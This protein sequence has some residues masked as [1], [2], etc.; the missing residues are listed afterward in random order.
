MND[1]TATMHRW[2]ELLNH[3]DSDGIVDL[4][5]ESPYI[6]NA[7]SPELSG[8]VAA[9]TLVNG[10]F[11]RTTER[12]FLVHGTALGSTHSFAWWTATLTFKAGSTVAGR[13]LAEPF[14]AEIEGIDV[15]AF[16]QA[17]LIQTVH[18]IHETTTVALAAAQHAVA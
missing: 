6:K 7:A 9:R 12:S 15:F 5:A 2:F 14:S 8:P 1:H 16:D 18:I 4:F 10:F 3:G 13:I 17:G 11:A